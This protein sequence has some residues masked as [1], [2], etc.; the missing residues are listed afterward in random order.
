[1][2]LP[3]A[4][5]THFTRATRRNAAVVIAALVVTVLLPGC[6]SKGGS[7]GARPAWIDNPGEGVSAAAG[8][9]VRGVQAQEE[10]AIARAREEY[11]KRYGVKVSGELR[12]EQRVTDQGAT[13]TSQSTGVQ[14]M[15]GNEVKARVR[16]KWLD[17]NSNFL[18]VWLVPSGK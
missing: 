9:H 1:M 4:H 2:T 12:T 13:M 11:A 3:M 15:D 7:P 10:L 16:A 6:G 18:W 14:A 17:P 5:F 8:Y